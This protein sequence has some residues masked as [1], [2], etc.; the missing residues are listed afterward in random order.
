MYAP[1]GSYK[2]PAI[3]NLL[4]KAMKLQPWYIIHLRVSQELA[5]RNGP[6]SVTG[7]D[8][9]PATWMC[10]AVF[11]LRIWHQNQSFSVEAASSQRSFSYCE[12][13]PSV[14]DY[15]GCLLRRRRRAEVNHLRRF[16]WQGR[17][18][19]ACRRFA[20]ASVD[21]SGPHYGYGA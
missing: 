20:T 11:S 7:P 13:S 18:S 21:V 12:A 19:R 9:E 10:Q 6:V 16:L 17:C 15:G 2:S 5:S 14:A 4:N 3:S 1:H 8:K